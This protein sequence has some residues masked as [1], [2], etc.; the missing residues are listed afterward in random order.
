[1]TIEK[2]LKELILKRFHSIRDFT[3]A[4]GLPYT[5]LDSMFRRGIGNSSVTNVI[6]VCNALDISVDA[7]ANGEIAPKQ[8]KTVVN[9]KTIFGNTEVTDLVEDMKEVLTTTGGLTVD[10]KPMTVGSIDSLIDAM[11]IG[12]EMAKKKTITKNNRFNETI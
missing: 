11:D 5:T 10:G 6:K 9:N 8:R 4:I 7:L 2:Q 3:N 12:V 1:M